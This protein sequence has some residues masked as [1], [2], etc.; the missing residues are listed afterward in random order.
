MKPMVRL[1]DGFDYYPYTLL[2]VD[3]ILWTH[4]DA[5]SVLMKVDKYFRLKPDSVEEPDMYL[6]S[7]LRP[8]NIENGVWAWALSPSQY[9]Q[10]SFRNVQKYVGKYRRK[11]EVIKSVS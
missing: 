11:M 5:D 9:V 8:T 1:S 4:H 7:K 3:V 10:K 6:G 2:Y